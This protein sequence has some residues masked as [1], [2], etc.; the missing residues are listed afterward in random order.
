MA[1]QLRNHQELSREHTVSRPWSD[2]GDTVVESYSPELE[3]EKKL[4][5]ESTDPFLVT[6]D[7]DHDP[8]HPWVSD[9]LRQAQAR[10]TF[11]QHWSLLKKWSLTVFGSILVM[12]AYVSSPRQVLHTLRMR[13]MRLR[14]SVHPPHL[15]REG[16]TRCH[17]LDLIL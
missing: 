4:E 5:E 9:I 17:L 14:T 6:W 15:R 2:D 1:S 7:G 12:N 16:V 3:L 13:Q 10:L 11:V 8:E